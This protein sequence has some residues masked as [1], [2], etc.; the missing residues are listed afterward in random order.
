MGGSQLVPCQLISI[1]VVLRQAFCYYTVQG[2][3]F[4]QLF[5]E[6]NLRL[7]CSIAAV[8]KAVLVI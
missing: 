8:Q 5:H 4:L 3:R 7:D 2:D 1:N 6:L